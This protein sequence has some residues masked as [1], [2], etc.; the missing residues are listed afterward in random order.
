M[1]H[2]AYDRLEKLYKW[3]TFTLNNVSIEK[4]F[5]EQPPVETVW[6]HAENIICSCFAHFKLKKKRERS[7]LNVETGAIHTVYLVTF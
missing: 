3:Q 6:M 1:L 4:A 7:N 2:S 5:V